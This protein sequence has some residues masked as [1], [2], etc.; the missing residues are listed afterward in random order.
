MKKISILGSTGSIGIQ[1][2]NVIRNIG[3]NFK[4]VGLSSNSNISELKKQIKEFK[5]LVAAIWD[6]NLAV[7]LIRWCKN[8][9]IKTKIYTGVDGLMTVA[10]VKDADLVLSSVVGAVGLI[11]LLEAIKNKKDIALANKEAL[12]IAGDIIKREADK[13]KVKII[14]VDSEHSAIF[15]CLKNEQ[16]DN[17]KRLILTASGG[18]FYRAKE[19]RHDLSVEEALDHPTWKMGPKITIDS[20]TLMNKG[21]EAIEAHYFFNTPLD[22]IDI[23]IHPQSIVHSLV[24]FIDGSVIA[25]LS[26]PDMRLPIQ[27]AVTYPKRYESNVKTLNLAGLKRL[28]FDHPD[29]RKFPCLKLALEAGKTGGT[30]TTV[31]NAANEIAVNSFLNKKIYFGQIPQIISKIMEKHKLIRKPQLEDILYADEW[32]RKNTLEAISKIKD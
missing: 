12:I 2:I 15:Q 7:E 21:L 13:N 31:M 4:I 16:E 1:A 27:Y 3:K 24:E 17:I 18:P 30:M 28:E 20:A 8:N 14:P 32:A 9:K 11:P 10:S 25:Q 29:F 26:N 19:L 22:K 6:E 23:L 5:P